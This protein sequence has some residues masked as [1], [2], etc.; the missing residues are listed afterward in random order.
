MKRTLL[1]TSSAL[2][3]SALCAQQVIISENFD[4]YAAGNPLAQTL[5]LPWTTWSS[6]PGTTEDASLSAAQAYSGTLS[7][8]II[9]TAPTGGP[10]DLVLQLGNR[11][12]GRY[13]L[14]WWM[15]IAGGKG[16]YFNLQKS[17]TPGESW[18]L[19]V[20]FRANG[21][22]ELSPNATAGV[23]SAYPSDEWFVVGM[24]IDLNAQSGLLTIN[25][26]PAASWMTTSASGS[27]GAGLNQ[28]GAVNF[29][30]YAGGDLCEYYIDDV[31][32]ADLTGVGIDEAQAPA[33]NAFPNPTDGR[34]TI[35]LAGLSASASVSVC[36]LTG[37][38]VLSGLALLRRG[39]GARAEV[40]LSGHPSGVYFVRVQD[41]G[42]ELVRRVTK[43]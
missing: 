33:V 14:G 7:G 21:T 26:Q 6:A 40:D 2:I 30:S 12:S 5:G 29:F 43:H 3:A 41:G 17:T 38:Q 31:T 28:I 32:F 37:R 15:Y 16:G 8:A 23:T 35:D 25:G 9:S 42:R 13:A 11:T 36:D 34:F 20:T 18:A 4:S 22:I 24:L 10:T 39:A 19:D 1:A 27:G